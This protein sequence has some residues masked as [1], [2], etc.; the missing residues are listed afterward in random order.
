METIQQ[1]FVVVPVQRLDL[2]GLLDGRAADAG[3]FGV[4]VGR[5]V[6]VEMAF[7]RV[8][9]GTDEVLRVHE[10][11][12]LVGLFDGDHFRVHAEIAAAGMAHLQP[13][14]PVLAVRQRQ[15]AGQ[16]QP[17]AFAGNLLQFLIQPDRVGLQLGHVRVAVQRVKPARRMPCGPAG[18]P[19]PLQQHDVRPARFREV[20]KDG[21]ADDAAADDCDLG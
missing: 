4:G 2:A 19:V 3:G 16:M 12:H 11:E 7:D 17:A 18:E 21:T 5:A 1:P 13:V 9:H 10:R 6:G 8:P 20:V 15:P 14:E